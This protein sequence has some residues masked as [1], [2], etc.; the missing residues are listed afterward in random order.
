MGCDTENLSGLKHTFYLFLVQVLFL[1]PFE[2]RTLSL[3]TPGW[4][5]GGR[6]EGGGPSGQVAAVLNTVN[7][8]A[9]GKPD[10]GAEMLPWGAFAF[11]SREMSCHTYF[12]VHRKYNPTCVDGETAWNLQ[13]TIPMTTG[14]QLTT[15]FRCSESSFDIYANMINCYN[16]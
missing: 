7:Q 1:L 9:G 12:Q 15:T 11:C 16:L 10:V 4:D 3:M 13:T 6:V 5:G 14:A 2:S 8:Q